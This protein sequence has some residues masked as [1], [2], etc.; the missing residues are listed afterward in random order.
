MEKTTITVKEDLRRKLVID[1]NMLG[2]KTVDEMIRRLY[3][4]VEKIQGDENESL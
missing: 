4:I 2:L 3:T 1:K